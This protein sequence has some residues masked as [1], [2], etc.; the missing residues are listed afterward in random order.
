MKLKLIHLFP[1][2]IIA[3]TQ[4]M[5]I[6]QF[7]SL[8]NAKELR[9]YHALGAKAPS[10]SVDGPLLGPLLISR[11]SGS[12]GNRK[13]C[14]LNSYKVQNHI[15]NHFKNLDWY[16]EED[17]F[18]QTTP[19]GEI[20]FKNI[21]VTKNIRAHRRL[22]LAAHFDSKHFDDFDFIG[23]TDSAAPCAILM[24]IAS[25]L[26]D[27]LNLQF[28]GYSTLQIIFFDGEEA[29]IQWTDNDSIYG[30]KHL[31]NSWANTMYTVYNEDRTISHEISPIN[32]MDALVLLDLLGTK[33]AVVP[34]SQPS[35]QWLWDRLAR[36][37]E[38]L[39]ILKLLSPFML[40]RMKKGNYMFP[41]GSPL[42]A[43]NAIQVFHIESNKRMITFLSKY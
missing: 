3:T 22:T 19:F 13:V 29:M 24:H 2:F 33:D 34:N 15:I 43:S 8:S 10:L 32:Q 25:S 41:A 5:L 31:A 17:H 16:I 38:K 26:N 6:N 40:E 23:A 7:R 28:G 21:I 30:A 18:N 11:V 20:A 4:R 42:Y 1:L 12:D 14:L 35:T 39:G 37:H 36:I 9:K 27:K